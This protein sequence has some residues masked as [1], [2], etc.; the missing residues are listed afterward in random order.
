[1]AKRKFR[2]N[3]KALWPFI[4]LIIAALTIRAVFAANKDLSI[5]ALFK[6]LNDAKP[7]WLIGTVICMLG[8]IA[9]EGF[10]LKHILKSA[11]IK[12]RPM[13][14][15]LYAASDQFFSAITPSATGG[16]PAS[17]LFMGANGIPTATITVALLINLIMYTTSTVVIGLFCII[18][19]PNLL[20]SLTVP[21]KILIL[22]GMTVM[23][24]LTIL[25]IALLRRGAKLHSLGIKL[26]NFLCRIH[27]M[28]RK[29]HWLSRLDHVVY[30]Y[31]LCSDA[32]SGNAKVLALAFLL[33]LGQKISQISVTPLLNFAFKKPDFVQGFN[34]WILQAFSQVGSYCVPIPGGMGATD[35]IMLD[36]FALLFDEDYTFIL[37]TIS[38][39]ISFYICTI[40]TGLIV[41]T[42]YI[43]LKIRAGKKRSN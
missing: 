15:L 28:H 29:E 36:G 7:G 22:L 25:F 27:L 5:W 31:T 33:N 35:Y 30:D 32:L 21:S 8:F 34:L 16:Q 24:V 1:M 26:I 43:V 23:T 4:T 38:R 19:R 17:A 12:V 3:R 20:M 11:N 14:G 42:G 40:V 9:F 13:Q 37:E 18:A 39:S 10:A 2:F 6:T 41:L